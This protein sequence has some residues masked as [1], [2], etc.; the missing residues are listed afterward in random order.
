MTF[1][2]RQ[3][4]R[5]DAVNVVAHGAFLQRGAALDELH[6][7]DALELHAELLLHRERVGLHRDET[8]RVRADH[9][10]AA[11]AMSS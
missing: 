2:H 6:E 9:P 1:V 8:W 3:V 7:A 5:P 10:V 4:E 11:A